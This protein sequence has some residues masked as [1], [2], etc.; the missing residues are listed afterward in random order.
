MRY[1]GRRRPHAASRR[2]GSK[3]PDAN[4]ILPTEFPTDTLPGTPERI[5][6]M[7]HRCRDKRSLWDEHGRE[8]P[9]AAWSLKT[10][11][12]LLGE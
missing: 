7:C 8:L 2:V 10:F 12:L 3:L 6:V 1:F 9:K 11:R 4:R 5:D